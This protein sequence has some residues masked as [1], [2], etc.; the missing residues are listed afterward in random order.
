MNLSPYSNTLCH[1]VLW[2][3]CMKDVFN[4]LEIL[5]DDILKENYKIDTN[6]L[7]KNTPEDVAKLYHPDTFAQIIKLRNSLSSIDMLFGE[8][9]NSFSNDDFTY[10]HEIVMFVRMVMSQCMLH[11]SAN[12]GFNG[13]KTRGT[14]NTK[15]ESILSYYRKIGEEPKKVNI[16]DKMTSYI[17]KMDLDVF[18]IRKRF[19]KLHRNMM[20]CDARKLNL[21]NKCIDMVLTSPPYFDVLSYG[22]SNWVRHW[23]IKNIGDPLVK[24]DVIKTIDSSNSSEIYGKIFDK[25]T[26]STRSTVSNCPEYAAFT[27][28]YLRELYRVLKDDAVAII[29]VGN[30]GNKRK[31]DA[32]RIV[33]DR[34]KLLG[35]KSQM[36]IMDELNKNLKSSS[37]FNSKQGGGKNNYDVAVVLYKGKYVRKNDPENIDFQ[38]RVRI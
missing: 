37:Q 10:N 27:G 36:V 2:T 32:W 35:F 3:P 31:I 22:Q 15:T 7:G 28:L 17:E 33:S 34:A 5:K 29:V 14:D 20:S 13:I 9:I 19:S 21:P 25:A 12:M 6:Y 8:D 38:W 30:Y 18:G 24:N 1:S 16:F 4:Y 11:S 23:S 26:D